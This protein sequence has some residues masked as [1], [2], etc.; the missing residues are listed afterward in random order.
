MLHPR[1]ETRNTLR[2]KSARP[3]GEARRRRYVYVKNGDA[4]DQVRRVLQD[5]S[6]GYSSGPDAFIGDFLRAHRNDDLLVLCS[7]RP[8]P[9]FFVSDRIR[10]RG[11][12]DARGP[13][14]RLARAWTAVRIAVDIYRFRPDRVLC[15][16]TGELLWASLLAAKLRGALIV[17]SRHNALQADTLLQHVARALDR[18]C[19]RACTGVV[20][21]GPFLSDQMRALGVPSSRTRQF[22]VD[23][24]Q[25]AATAARTPVPE[26][27]RAFVAGF[28]NV[29]MFVGRVQRDKGIFD[30]LDAYGTLPELL[31]ERTAI[32]YAGNGKHLGALRE[33]VA[34]RRLDTHVMLLGEVPH[35]QL[36]AVMRTA[37][38]VLA[39]TRP[40][41]SEGRCK[42]IPEALVLGI[43]VIGP[44]FGPFPY[45]IRHDVDGLLFEPG[46]VAALGESL[47]RVC[48]DRLFLQ[49]LRNGAQV[50]AR[51]ILKEEAGFARAV[52]LAFGGQERVC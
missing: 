44:N 29:L 33:E 23:F 25:F 21:H 24:A 40:E 18:V 51:R 35:Q 14:R 16:C 5:T 42:V 41:F 27:L 46:S 2:E 6:C 34:H 49:R 13:L 26:N 19:I 3:E 12:A 4:V 11:Y 31:R 17:N 22:G 39:P 45:G 43:P 1:D 9:E 7:Q 10:A 47:A 20:C 30:L 28:D 50:S 32:V 38:V 15:G 36:A 37:T 52:D 8:R 48:G